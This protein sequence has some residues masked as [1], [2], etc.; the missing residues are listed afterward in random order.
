MPPRQS[1]DELLIRAGLTAVAEARPGSL[2]P[3]EAGWRIARGIAA[4]DG[5][6]VEELDATWWRRLTG[7]DGEFLV[8]LG[9]H[10]IGGNDAWWTRV[11]A[12]NVMPRLTARVPSRS[13][14][15]S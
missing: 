5:A 1:L 6:T 3:P 8:A 9:G 15:R 2:F 10:R 14:A 11:R 12:T 13:G 4:P 7:V